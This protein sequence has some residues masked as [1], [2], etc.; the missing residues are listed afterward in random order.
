M[1]VL[2]KCYYVTVLFTLISLRQ[3]LSGTGQ[4]VQGSRINKRLEQAVLV[5]WRD[6]CER[7]E[8]FF[9]IFR[10]LQQFL[11]LLS[12]F[13]NNGDIPNIKLNKG[14]TGIISGGK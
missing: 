6:L 1:N 5:M 11:H 7:G 10:K 14:K 3:L 4:Q 12:S 13:A 2:R 9:L 8:S